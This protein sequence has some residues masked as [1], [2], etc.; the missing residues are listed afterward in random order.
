MNGGDVTNVKNK[1]TGP[2]DAEIMT[3]AEAARLLRCTSQTL[4]KKV[5]NSEIPCFRL[6]KNGH[7]RFEKKK[8]LEW[9]QKQNG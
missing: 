4:Y 5:A 6:G 9:M 7:F 2:K 3:L 1:E 8:L